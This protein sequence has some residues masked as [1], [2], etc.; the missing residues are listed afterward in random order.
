MLTHAEAKRRAELLDVRS[1]DI[2]LDLTR[3]DQEFGSATRVAFSCAE[4]GES[5][6]AELTPTRLRRAALN[7]VEIDLDQCVDGRI[8]L[9]DL[10]S[11]N[12]LLV[13]ADMPYSRTGEGLHH[14]VDPADGETYLYAQSCMDFAQ[15]I[16]ACFDQPDLK[17]PVRLK[18]TAPEGW[19]VIGNGAATQVSPGRW[20]MAETAPLAT[21]FVTL[22]AGPY[23]SV[24]SEHDGVPLGLHCRR[25]LA[26]HLDP[27]VD[28]LF[29]VTRQCLDRYHELFALRYPYGKYDQVFVPE[30]NAG[31]M[32]N[33]G[34]VVFRDGLVFRSAPTEAQREVRAMVLAHEMAHMWFGDLVTLRWWDD[35][36]LNESFAE[37]M[38]HRVTTEVTRFTEAWTTF[39]LTRKTWGYAADQRPSTHP[40]ASEV[41]DTAQAMLNFDGISYAKGASVLRQLVTWLGDDVFFAGLN[42]YFARHQHG[43][44]T[45][46]DL[47]DAL[48]RHTDRDLQ[49]WARSWLTKPQLNTLRPVVSADADGQLE[50]V[51]VEQSAP[52]AYPTLRPHR[53]AIGLYDADSAG[54]ALRRQRQLTVDLDP[55]ADGSRVAVPELAGVKRPALLLLNDEDLTYAKVRFDPD[56]W[57]TLT[58][59]LS[60]VEDPLTRALIWCAAWDMV[61]D[62][63]LPV[64][65]YFTLTRAHLPHETAIGTLGGVLHNALSPAASWYTPPQQRDAAL[66][67]LAGACRELLQAAEP[68]GSRQLT[69][70]RGMARC[71]L[72][73]QDLALVRGWLT[74]EGVP[75]GL[76]IG[77]DLRWAI[78]LRLAVLGAVG[79]VEIDAELAA[80]PSDEGQQGA[81]RCRAALSDPASKARTWETIAHGSLAAQTL[82][83]TVEGF[84]QPEHADVLEDY[85]ARYFTELPEITARRNSPEIDRILGRVGFPGYAAS[86]VVVTM[87]EKML[88][89]DDLRPAVARTVGDELDEMRRAVR[90]RASA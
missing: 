44:A 17:A 67:Q 85:V 43:N 51:E 6:F 30:F 87:A 35:L 60:R 82:F 3:G 37:Y 49:A 11:D 5:S 9:S 76:T 73:P 86:P 41:N 78:L 7:G 88:G 16:F 45:L 4:P 55:V 27:D 57:T 38:G 59:Q 79:E 8:P 34:C 63:E 70:A 13:E 53:I 90:A 28:E 19:T 71:A 32:E 80:D 18:V 1:Y 74:G 2:D 47:L 39:S 40:I 65:E 10:A 23:H 50:S 75:T 89:R 25:S 58:Q 22:A 83:A 77:S 31:A 84:W 54:G 21:Y 68:G 42:D 36:W 61:R 69:A 72:D 20:E 33:P 48:S 26:A 12:E 29:T 62:G 52:E 46:A 24:R 66:A 64:A 14:F 15:R 81:A 56:S